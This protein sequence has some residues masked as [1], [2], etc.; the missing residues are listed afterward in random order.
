[1]THRLVNENT[2]DKIL[3]NLIQKLRFCIKRKI[4]GYE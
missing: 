4:D 3:A 2:K 1:M